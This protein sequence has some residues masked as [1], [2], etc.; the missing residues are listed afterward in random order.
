MH[1]SRVENINMHQ[2]EILEIKNTIRDKKT[3]FNVEQSLVEQRL[4]KAEQ[5]IQGQWENYQRCDACI[6]GILEKGEGI[7]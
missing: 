1:V 3:D 5:N 6:M 7:K 4:T 2:K